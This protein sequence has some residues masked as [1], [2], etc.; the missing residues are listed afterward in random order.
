[1]SVLLGYAHFIGLSEFH[2]I[3]AA[4]KF[5]LTM[6][7]GL[8]VT[9]KPDRERLYFPVSSNIT[10]ADAF[11]TRW[12][13]NSNYYIPFYL[14]SVKQQGSLVVGM[15][16][17]GMEVSHVLTLSYCVSIR[18]VLTQDRYEK[19]TN[20]RQILRLRPVPRKLP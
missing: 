16:V 4:I 15:E 9:M 3:F 13:P 11:D 14:A 7:Q 18:A 12:M 6:V 20:A 17:V 2:N 19:A 1:M 8:T 10:R 5:F